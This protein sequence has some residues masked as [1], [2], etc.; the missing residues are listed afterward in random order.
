MTQCF[1]VFTIVRAFPIPPT[2]TKPSVSSKR[3][4]RK[5]TLAPS[6]GF[7]VSRRAIGTLSYQSPMNPL[8][9]TLARWISWGHFFTDG[10]GGAETEDPRLRR[11][12]DGV[13]WIFS[14]GG[15]LHTLG[16][17]AGILHGRNQSV[18]RAELRAAVEALR[19]ARKATRQVIIWTDC[20]FVINGFARGRRRKHLS[21]AD[22]W[23]EFWK[24]HDAISPPVQLHKVWRSHATE[25]GIA[26][27][28][29][30]PLEA[31]GNEVADKLASRGAR[32]KALSMEYAAATRSTDLRVRLVQTRLV[33][34]IL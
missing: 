5:P 34:M 21:H 2:W 8:S 13:T 11:C 16:G 32:R 31:C 18:A 15:L 29:I 27:G 24:A 23:V 33:E 30:S 4:E 14:D 22:L 26:A 25:A 1:I 17:R 7:I 10:S 20:M 6:F 12:G 3:P 19:L 9:R 28:L